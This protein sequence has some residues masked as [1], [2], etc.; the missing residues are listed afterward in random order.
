MGLAYAQEY[1]VP[2]DA[3]PIII[4]N[5]FIVTFYEP[6]GFISG[7]LTFEDVEVQLQSLE[8][9]T[10][11][12][13]V[14]LVK[15]DESNLSAILSDSRV[16][17]VNPNKL[18]PLH[19]FSGDMS[20]GKDR[21]EADL[22][23]NY[24]DGVDDKTNADVAVM[25]TG[26]LQSNPDYNIVTCID[27]TGGGSCGDNN[28][29]GSHTAGTVGAIDN[30]GNNIIGVAEGV[31]LHILKVC[32]TGSCPT[33]AMIAAS[34]YVTANADVIDV[35][36]MSIGGSQSVPNRTCTGVTNAWQQAIC[37]GYE[38]GV[39]YVVSAGNGN[40]DSSGTVVPCTWD[41]TLCV[42]AMTDSD[43]K[44][45]GLGPNPDC[46]PFEQDDVM[47][48]FSN[49]GEVVRINAPGV[50]EASYDRF[51]NVWRISGTS[52]S[53]PHVAGSAALAT[54]DFLNPT[55]AAEVELVRQFL[56]DQGFPRDSPEGWTGDKDSFAEPLVQVAFATGP[57]PPTVN[58]LLI[59][60]FT[61]S[62]LIVNQGEIVD[63]QATIKNNGTTSIAKS[64]IF[65]RDTLTQTGIAAQF[66]IP[67]APGETVLGEIRQWDT[68]DAIVGD[69]I[70]RA[71]ARGLVTDDNPFNDDKFVLVT[72]LEPLD[73]PGQV[74]KNTAD[75]KVLKDL[76][77]IQATILDE[78]GGVQIWIIIT[79]TIGWITITISIL[80]T[81]RKG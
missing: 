78:D 35:V 26:I 4:P 49:F 62:P 42:S 41:S 9:Y 65:Y 23:A 27:F 46:R 18:W 29:H 64:M 3:E 6:T 28:G 31:R 74:A 38:K 51:G 67:L 24:A 7:E 79:I 45:G 56:I 44:A 30:G 39:I 33:S 13:Q 8:T 54:T 48:T 14:F 20:F 77:G 36:N 76:H 32:P 69:H 15:T 52:M 16:H 53:A 21:I 37:N 17:Y 11:T 55:N 72:V 80:V 71:I 10:G 75:I 70:L 40:K 63:M 47:A 5:E 12:N 50:C 34:D 22:R 61:A 25:D 2:T 58:D 43:G 68:T 59:E 19:G 1:E 81:R 57:P 73:L 66:R 60:S